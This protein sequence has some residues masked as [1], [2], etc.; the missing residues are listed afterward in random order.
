MNRNSRINVHFICND[1][2]AIL[3]VAIKKMAKNICRNCSLK[4]K[5]LFY[6]P[7]MTKTALNGNLFLVNGDRIKTPPLS[8]GCLN[9]VM[10]KQILKLLLELPDYLI[11]EGAVSPFELQKADELFITN[12]IK[13]IVPISKYRKKTYGNDFTKKLVDKLNTKIRLGA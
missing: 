9:G 11:E 6:C 13:G 1:Y 5:T 4:T 7:L 10:R 12:V 2:F 8:S 3:I